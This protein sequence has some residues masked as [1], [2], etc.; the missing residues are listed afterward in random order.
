MVSLLFLSII[1]QLLRLVH[2]FVEASV[3]DDLR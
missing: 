3:T 1:G 2:H